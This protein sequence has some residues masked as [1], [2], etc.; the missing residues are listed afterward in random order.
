MHNRVVVPFN[1]YRIEK[2]KEIDG[3]EPGLASADLGLA[4]G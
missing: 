4:I 1:V 2:T 3:Y